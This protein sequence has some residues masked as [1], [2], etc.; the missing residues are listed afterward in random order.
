MHGRSIF[1]QYVLFR[2]VEI[3][4]AQHERRLQ[5]LFLIITIPSSPVSV[6]TGPGGS[7]S[8]V[9]GIT[10][11]PPLGLELSKAPWYSFTSIDFQLPP[12]GYSPDDEPKNCMHVNF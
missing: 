3:G 1:S 4:T 12:L 7:G 6:H 5:R 2:K 10:R 9:P 11:P 8:P